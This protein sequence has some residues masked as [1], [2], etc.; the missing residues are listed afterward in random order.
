M[1]TLVQLEFDEA[2]EDFIICYMLNIPECDGESGLR[3]TSR[4]GANSG[5]L[6]STPAASTHPLDDKDYDG[7]DQESDA[8]NGWSAKDNAA[9]EEAEKFD[10]VS[11][12]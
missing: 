1:S 7:L 3:G 6:P 12:L 8:W 5:A 4:G 9:M 10:D 11:V 2:D